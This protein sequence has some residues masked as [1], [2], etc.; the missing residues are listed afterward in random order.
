MKANERLYDRMLWVLF[1]FLGLT[2]LGLERNLISENR[3]TADDHTLYFSQMADGG[4]YLTRIVLANPGTTDINIT[5]E[6]FQSDGTPLTITLNGATGSSFTWNIKARGALFLKTSGTEAQVSVGWIRVKG[7][8]AF[9]GS[10]VYGYISGGKAISEAGLD[11]STP[12]T[13]FCYTVDMRHNYYSGLA[14]ANPSSTSLEIRYALY[15]VDGNLKGQ[16][17]Q[18]LGAMQHTAKL[19]YEIFPS[20]NLTDFTGTVTAIS[21]AGSVI[22]TTLRFDPEVGTLAS[23]PVMAGL[24]IATG[25]TSNLTSSTITTTS[26]PSTTTSSASTTTST[27]VP[28]INI[29]GVLDVPSAGQTVSS[30]LVGSGWALI[31]EGNTGI[32]PSKIEI[33]VDGTV[34]A[35]AEQGKS[36]PDVKTYFA[37]LGITV[38]AD[39]GYSF[40]WATFQAAQGNHTMVIQATDGTGRTGRTGEIARINVTTPANN[41]NLYAVDSIVGNLYLV[42][43]GTFTQGTPPAEVGRSASEGQQF[44]HIL[45]KRLAVMET[46][47]SCQMWANLKSKQTTLMDDP[48]TSSSEGLAA[49]VN[50]VSWTEMLLFANL[51]SLQQGMQRVYYS[52]AALSTAISSTNYAGGSCFADWN[53]NGYRL[54]T[55]AEREYYTRG[56]TT[57]PFSV[58]AL[59]YTRSIL[60]LF[61]LVSLSSTQV[62]GQFGATTQYFAQVAAGPEAMT[63]FSIHNPGSTPSNVRLEMR[64][65]DGSAFHDSTVA[66]PAG[67]LQTVTIGRGVS[68]LKVGWARLSATSGEFTA[69][70]SFQLKSGGMNL[71]VVGVLP[72]S[73]VSR[74]RIFGL[75][76]AVSNTGIAIANPSET[77]SA[78]LT[79]RLLTNSGTMLMMTT[80]TLGPRMHSSRFLNETPWFPGLLNYEGMIDIESTEPIILTMLRSDNNSFS[81]APILTPM[82]AGLPI[83][84][85]TTDYLAE[86]AVTTAKVQNAAITSDKIAEGAIGFAQLAADVNNY[87]NMVNAA[88]LTLWEPSDGKTRLLI[89][90]VSNEGGLDTGIVITNT[91]QDP[92]GTSGKTGTATVYYYG[93]M[94][95]GGQLPAPQT[96]FSI[97]PGHSFSFSLSTGGVSGSVSSTSGFQGYVIIVCNFPFG[98]GHYVIT[99]LGMNRIAWGGEALI[100][101]PTRDPTRTES[102]GH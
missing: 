91:G 86:G 78:N 75:I 22:A 60:F 42:P 18:L 48:S 83:G 68:T 8:G 84:S 76:N 23:I 62:L 59:M 10:L 43:A 49:P 19:L 34:A 102:R 65:S 50:N 9:G 100:L 2:A 51:L 73:P 88:M 72:M 66:I 80:I 5:L 6:P 11:P 69:S 40:T 4:G 92:M 90:F 47:V 61:L 101:P 31:L 38:P 94:T 45:T 77:N 3:V 98:H 96:T 21:S 20:L 67:G 56:G 24:A 29:R 39:T 70:E 79:V 36:R 12:V 71:P 99:D 87:F 46:S 16:S 89:P 26:F 41:T 33:L 14:V 17:T 74:L 13:Q 7:T 55:E 52:D 63:T 57:G 54:P 93:G 15:D 27:L 37:S 25:P 1:V 85:V 82:T 32:L 35:T 53:A 95:S 44:K 81:S 58:E 97:S 28:P 64:A 30:F